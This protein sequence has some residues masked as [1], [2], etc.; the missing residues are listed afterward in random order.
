MTIVGSSGNHK[1][2]TQMW[3]T[4]PL[5][6][7]AGNSNTMNQQDQRS[8]ASRITR[9]DTPG[10]N[11]HLRAS[12]DH[13][14]VSELISTL[15]LNL[16]LHQSTIRIKHIQNWCVLTLCADTQLAKGFFA[17]NRQK[18]MAGEKSLY[19]KSYRTGR[20]WLQTRLFGSFHGLTLAKLQAPLKAAHSSPLPHHCHHCHNWAEER[21]N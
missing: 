10:M 7:K 12:R 3:K 16:A 17:C 14:S 8:D 15:M 19:G 11:D 9:G 2:K 20:E 6:E 4:Y 5:K 1:G 21:K 13:A 18:C